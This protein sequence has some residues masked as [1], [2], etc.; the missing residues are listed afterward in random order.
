MT[1]DELQAHMEGFLSLGQAAQR[2]WIS[3]Q[4]LR[5]LVAAGDLRVLRTPAGP[6]IPRDAVLALQQPPTGF[7]LKLLFPAQGAPSRVPGGI[8]P[9]GFS[10]QKAR[11]YQRLVAGV[12]VA[13]YLTGV[14]RIVAFGTVVP[15]TPSSPPV[16]ADFPLE[17]LVRL[18]AVASPG[19]TRAQAGLSRIRPRSG[20]TLFW[21]QPGEWAAL[22]TAFLA[23][24]G[25]SAIPGYG[26]PPLRHM[27]AG[28][29]RPAS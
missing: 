14:R 22:Q 17:R 10:G 16:N 21:L 4:A 29:D 3:R 2:L 20:D 23:Q 11:A 24:P 12:E 9:V 6:L 26:P 15:G 13:L 25:A 8:E 1:I 27:P 7:A 19:L 18:N 28:N 5:Q